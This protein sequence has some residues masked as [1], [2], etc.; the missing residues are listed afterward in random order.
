MDWLGPATFNS[1]AVLQAA[2][3]AFVA[4]LTAPASILTRPL[5]SNASRP[6]KAGLQVPWTP[7]GFVA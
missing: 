2:V 5:G 7:K 3:R 4:T 1:D 6:S